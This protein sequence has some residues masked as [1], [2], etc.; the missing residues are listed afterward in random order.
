MGIMYVC[1]FVM[2]NA[3]NIE[4]FQLHII[5]SFLACKQDGVPGWHD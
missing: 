4:I 2:Y 5:E 1:I 3:I